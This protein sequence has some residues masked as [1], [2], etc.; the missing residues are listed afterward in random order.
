MRDM[1]RS[2][3]QKRH[4]GEVL[5][6][7]N[8]HR[9]A[10][11]SAIHLGLLGELAQDDRGGGHRDRAAKHDG[12]GQFDAEAPRDRR[13]QPGGDH[14]LA[15]TEPEHFPSH[16][17][18]SRERELQSQREHQEHDANLGQHAGGRVIGH[19]AQRMRS[20]QHTH[21]EIAEN[22][23]ELQAAYRIYHRHRCSEEYQD[24]NQRAMWH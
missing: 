16:R 18:Q 4:E 19:D 2:E 10:P 21:R 22:R 13:A 9:E 7:Q 20:K 24:L 12:D 6:Q 23:R 17:D 8:R 11:V 15:T 3:R 5:E 14:D 1:R